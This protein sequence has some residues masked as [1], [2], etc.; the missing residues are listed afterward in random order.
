MVHCDQVRVEQVAWNLVSNAIKFTPEGGRVTVTLAIDG[1]VREARLVVE[2]TGRGIE[3]PFL[4]HVFDMF[5]QGSAHGSGDRGLGI[6]LALVRELVEAQGGRIKVSSPGAGQGS[7]FTVTLPLAQA[8]ARIQAPAAAAALNP[9]QDLR[10]LI[11]DDS[12]E[13]LFFFGELLKLEDAQVDSANSGA[14]ALEKLQR[15]SY[16]LLISDLG[17]PEMSG[18]E[19]IA[20]VRKLPGV[21]RIR[22][23]A[24]SGYG[25]DVDADKAIS[26]GFDGHLSKPTS[27]EIL[28][29]TLLSL[30]AAGAD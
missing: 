18:Y 27:I 6:G 21:G 15:E 1:Q 19:L 23:L 4:P 5:S 3:A 20:A 17:M 25:R 11:V 9:L 16:D 28:K 26:V 14:E 24:L 13:T 12:K 8:R 7:V 10:V 30:Q 29:E 22:A 2:D